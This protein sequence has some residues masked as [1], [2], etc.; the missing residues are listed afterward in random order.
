[1][2]QAPDQA[3][4]PAAEAPARAIHIPQAIMI[5]D[6]AGLLDVTPIDLIKELMKSGV[7]APINQVVDFATAAVS[8]PPP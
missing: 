3:I 6:L 5:K 8:A 2:T 4:Q 7:M 1:M